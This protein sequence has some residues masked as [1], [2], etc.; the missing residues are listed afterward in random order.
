MVAT[1]DPTFLDLA[2]LQGGATVVTVE[3][4]QTDVPT[5]IPED[6]QIL[7]HDPHP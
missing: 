5:L 3:F 2:V 4:K 6:Y 1:P 7:A